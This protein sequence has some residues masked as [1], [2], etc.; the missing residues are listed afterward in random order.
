MYFVTYNAKPYVNGNLCNFTMYYNITK[1]E[2]PKLNITYDELKSITIDKIKNTTSFHFNDVVS[3]V[4]TFVNTTNTGFERPPNTTFENKLNHKDVGLIREVIWDL[5][6]QRV[7][8][9]GNFNG[10]AW[11]FLTVTEYGQK[12]LNSTEIIPHDPSKYI[13]RVKQDIPN[14]DRCYYNLFR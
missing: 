10:D 8:S 6:I 3:L 14:I 7:L 11:Q 5:I 9:I 12:V 2:L 13:Q 4:T 1:P